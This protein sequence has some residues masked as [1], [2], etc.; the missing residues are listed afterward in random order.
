MDGW[1][2]SRSCFVGVCT[3][4]L[5]CSPR[6]NVRLHTQRSLPQYETIISPVLHE[7]RDKTGQNETIPDFL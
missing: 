1:C 2:V 4:M 3:V 7:N 6:R 5:V